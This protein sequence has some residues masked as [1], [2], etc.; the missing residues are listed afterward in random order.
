MVEWDRMDSGIPNWVQWILM[1]NL[2]ASGGLLVKINKL[3]KPD[4]SQR[5]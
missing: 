1:A 2:D 5:P 4:E 3:I